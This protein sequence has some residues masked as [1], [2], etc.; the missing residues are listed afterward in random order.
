MSRKAEAT[1]A[2]PFGP[3]R[4]IQ[5]LCGAAGRPELSRAELAVLIVLA[6]HINTET[7][8][9]WPSFGRIANIAATTVRTAKRAVSRLTA[10]DLIQIAEHGGPGR[11]NRYRL[12]WARFQQDADGDTDD[13]MPSAMVTPVAPY[14][15]THGPN[16][17]SSMS[18]D[19]FNPSEQEA[20]D[21]IE[22]SQAEGV[23]APLRLGACGLPHSKDGYAAFWD[24]WGRR[25]TV[26]ETERLID[27]KM[28]EGASLADIIAGVARFR[29]YCSDTGKPPRMKPAAFVHGEKWRDDWILYPTQ[30]TRAKKGRTKA[31]VGPKRKQKRTAVR[32]KNP[33]VRNPAITQW[34]RDYRKEVKRVFN[35]L[36]IDSE[37]ITDDE[38]KSAM[39][40]I[41][42]WEQKNPKPHLYRN[43]ETGETWGQPGCKLPSAGWRTSN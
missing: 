25:V 2:A 4:K 24:A 9:A 3:V 13:T 23:A 31:S 40:L 43:K 34:S 29:K 15:D 41:Y 18:P 14:G 27:A 39:S 26:A 5:W 6:D 36:N 1:K 21:E 35:I 10:M 38:H 22:G 30:P 28:E 32:V 17:V 42:L 19:P 8:K 16:M 33:W 11:S 37:N 12:N 20:E 7:G